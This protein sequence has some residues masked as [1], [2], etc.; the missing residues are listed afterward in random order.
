MPTVKTQ[1]F[2]KG[3]HHATC[4]ARRRYLEKDERHIERICLNIA[5]PERWAK[6]M[7]KTR[8]VYRPRGS[9]TYREFILSPDVADDASVDT[10]RAMAIE[11]CKANFPDAEVT[12]ILHDDN[13]E[14]LS[15]EEAGIVHAHCVVNTVDLE[16]GRKVVLPND[17]VREL[18]NSLQRIGEKLGLSVQPDY[19]KGERLQSKQTRKRTLSERQIEL[20]DMQSWKTAVRDM[21]LQALSISTTPTEFTQCLDKADV[22]VVVDRGRIYLTDRDNPTRACRADRLDKKL[23]AKNLVQVFKEKNNQPKK[24]SSHLEQTI[25]RELAQGEQMR[26]EMQ[27]YDLRCRKALDGYKAVAKANKGVPH[28]RF[29]KFAMPRPET[30]AEKVRF[31]EVKLQFSMAAKRVRQQYEK[32]IPKKRPT[33]HHNQQQSHSRSTPSAPQQY[34]SR[35]RGR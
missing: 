5:N 9:V 3:G 23:S 30:E 27:Q 28:E 7:D 24:E 20:R 2:H 15:R 31:E 34:R 25:K 33:N 32:P 35:S 14:R 17:K 11:W 18:H 1:T 6:E 16:T 12:I 19:R 4:V 21:A 13:K 22:D 8:E 29:P 10:V 26:T